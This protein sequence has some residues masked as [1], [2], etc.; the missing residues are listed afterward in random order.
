MAEAR[1]HDIIRVYLDE[2]RVGLFSPLLKWCASQ[3]KAYHIIPHAEIEK[4]SGSVHHEGVCLLAKD[5]PPL[6]SQT[7]LASLA[8]GSACL[9]F[10]DGVEN[11]HNLG[12]I[13]RTAAHFGV[14][15]ILGE[16]LPSLPP[17]ACRIAK[18][19]AE[20]VRLV[21]LSNP[22]ET[23]RKLQSQGFSLLATSSHQGSSL[24]S[25][26]FSAKTILA[27]GSESKGVSPSIAK[28]ALGSICI[29]GTGAM[30]SL[31]VAV[32]SAL[33]IGAYFQQH[34]SSATWRL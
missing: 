2:E 31:N 7:F 23:L 19:G 9:I 28:F 15:Y 20:R 13:V 6:S 16:N 27:L 33:C 3:K 22:I 5:L 4:V 8:R 10:L 30:E 18:G 26:H 32:A 25:T 12:S 11:P 14:P 1:P 29:P 34:P 17:S 24:Y 21:S